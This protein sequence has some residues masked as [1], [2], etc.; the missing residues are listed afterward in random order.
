M[1]M[2]TDNLFEHARA[3]FQH[4]AARRILQE[5]YQGKMTFAHSGGLWRAGPELLNTLMAC[6]ANTAVLLDLHNTP[7]QI[8]VQELRTLAQQRWQE[9]MTAWL[10]EYQQMSTKR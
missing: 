6:D 3:R 7:V 5:K 1:D 2:D 9:Q 4:A 8:Q 10:A